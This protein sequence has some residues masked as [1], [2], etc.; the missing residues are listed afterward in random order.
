M[1][2][3]ISRLVGRKNRI[4]AIDEMT[5]FVGILEKSEKIVSSKYQE[6]L[7]EAY[8]TLARLHDEM[9]YLAYTRKY[10]SIALNIAKR[11]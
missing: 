4:K 11:I 1:K 3:K 8:W 9:H 5:S 10:A 2:F 7:M 6:A